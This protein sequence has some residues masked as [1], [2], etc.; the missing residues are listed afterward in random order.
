MRNPAL[1]IAAITKER[2]EKEIRPRL[3]APFNVLPFSV[4]KRTKGRGMYMVY[5]GHEF[6]KGGRK[7]ELKRLMKREAMAH[8][9]PALKRKAPKGWISATAVKIIRRGGQTQVLIRKPPRKRAKKKTAAKRR[10]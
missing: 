10:R 9:N 2:F 4:F 8:E 1:R 3:R 5:R 7:G 6:L